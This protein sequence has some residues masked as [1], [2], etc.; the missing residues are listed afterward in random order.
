M[1]CFLTCSVA[2]RESLWARNVSEVHWPL[3]AQA[4]ALVREKCLESRAQPDSCQADIASI[5]PSR[6]SGYRALGWRPKHPNR[7]RTRP[8]DRSF[9][10]LG[11]SLHIHRKILRQ[12]HSQS[13]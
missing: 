5:Q 12:T 10:A 2:N 8:I 9:Y 6:H 3:R 7:R 13:Q 4:Q 1:A 11:L